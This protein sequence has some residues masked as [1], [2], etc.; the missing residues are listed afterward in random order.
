[1][2][3]AGVIYPTGQTV[4]GYT[5]LNCQTYEAGST[6]VLERYLKSLEAKKQAKEVAKAQRKSE[7]ERLQRLEK[8]QRR[9]RREAKKITLRSLKQLLDEARFTGES[10]L[11]QRLL[12]QIDSVKRS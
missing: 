10:D 3:K 6:E 9:V 4:S 12:S 11:T 7:R 1:V 5:G 8:E 2:E